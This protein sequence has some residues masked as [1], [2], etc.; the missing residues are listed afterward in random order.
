MTLAECMV[1]RVSSGS[2]PAGVVELFAAGKLLKHYQVVRTIDLGSVVLEPGDEF[3][4]DV[5]KGFSITILIPGGDIDIP[6]H[7]WNLLTRTRAVLPA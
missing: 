2:S 6:T 5:S 1:E 3:A 4:A 7:K